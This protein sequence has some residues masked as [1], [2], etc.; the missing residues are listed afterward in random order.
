MLTPEQIL[1]QAHSVDDVRAGH[2]AALDH[3]EALVAQHKTALDL[4]QQLRLLHQQA[5]DQAEQAG[6]RAAEAVAVMQA[7]S[8]ALQRIDAAAK[9]IEI[10]ESN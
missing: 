3:A 4:A 5:L 1:A 6:R 9:F 2:A 8:A 10:V 7:Y